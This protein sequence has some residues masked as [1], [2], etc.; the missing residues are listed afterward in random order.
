M[1]CKGAKKT[2]KADKEYDVDMEYDGFD[3]DMEYDGFDMDMEDDY[4][5]CFQECRDKG[6]SKKACKNRCKI[7]DD[8]RR[9][10]RRDDKG[11]GLVCD[12]KSGRWMKKD[13]QDR[14]KRTRRSKDKQK[15]YSGDD[16]QGCRGTSRLRINS[17]S[18]KFTCVTNK[19]CFALGGKNVEVSGSNGS[20]WACRCVD[21]SHW[22]EGYKECQC[23]SGYEAIKKDGEWMECKS[24]RG[25]DHDN[26]VPFD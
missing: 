26:L 4:D 14:M 20:G 8:E 9:C 1:V 17:D 12:R 13:K 2:K 25:T 22:V 23:N 11:R 16:S 15:R 24:T 10:G 19:Q 7:T 3:M 21:N 6:R 18:G 5:S